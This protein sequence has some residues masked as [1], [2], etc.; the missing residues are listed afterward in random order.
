MSQGGK[1]AAA[2]RS[3]ACAGFIPPFPGKVLRARAGPDLRRGARVLIR[4]LHIGAK[5]DAPIIP[6]SSTRA[7]DH[8]YV[9]YVVQNGV[10]K[11]KVVTLGMNTKDGWVE[12]RSGL[13]AGEL[14]VVRGVESVTNGVKVTATQVDSLDPNATSVPVKNAAAPSGSA[15]PVGS[16]ARGSRRK[17]AGAAP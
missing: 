14:L 12:V 10:A 9:V 7:T 2:Q 3:F 4:P 15:A 1:S 11:E 6:R 17:A 16:G 8:G 5:R 13:A